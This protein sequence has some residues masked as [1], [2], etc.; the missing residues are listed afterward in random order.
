[1]EKSQKITLLANI[2]LV[3]FF[4]GVVFH[5]A[6]GFYLHL[7]Y[8][9]N[10]F[11]CIPNQAFSDFTSTLLRIRNF[12][13]YS[14][15]D[16]WMGYFPLA[17]ILLF[18]FSLIKNKL[19]AYLIFASGF[20]SF[21]TFMSTKNLYTKNLTKIQNFTNI[22]ILTF[23]TYPILYALDR[24]NFD[25]FLFV[26]FSGFIYAFK[27]EKYL[28][29]AVLL[30]VEN[31]IKPFPALFLI[32]FLLQKRFKEFFLSLAI[33]AL[34]IIGG[35]LILKGGF[36]DQIEV[37]IKNLVIFKKTWIY[38]DSSTGLSEASSLFAAL[39]FL[40]CGVNQ[41]IT[42]NLLEKIYSY[43]GFI[44]TSI[45][46][47]FTYKEKTYWKKV[48]L[49]TLNMLLVPYVIIDYKLIFLLVPIWL[50]V[51]S[52]EKTN[53][54]MIHTV[55]FGLLLISKKMFVLLV[56]TGHLSQLITYG[57]VINPLIMLV[58]I[59]L[60]IFEQFKKESNE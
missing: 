34:L 1:M 54:D 2:V 8:P 6:L 25:L 10:T 16:L 3:G 14:H 47:Y 43:I 28:L 32:L 18:P 50:F 60:I 36:F 24:G 49:L 17:Y 48:T 35:F 31:A 46:L 40:L 23:M 11:L 21:L 39:K 7:P 4:I 38:G 29:G 42:I 37:Y 59:G 22:F 13:P 58:F 55:L 51:N 45:T 33:S 30:G 44:I 5:Y 53:F 9:F 19:I 57:V 20:L 15:P 27:N 41:I 26:L 52:E 56:K 12:A